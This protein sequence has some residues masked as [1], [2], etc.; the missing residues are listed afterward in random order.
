M[1]KM[2]RFLSSEPIVKLEKAFSN[3]FRNLVATAQTCYSG[4]GIVSED[5]ITEDYRKLA[6]SIYKAGH[7]TTLQHAH[8]QFSISNVYRQFVWSF[9]HSHPFY[10]SEQV[11]QRY[12]AVKPGNFL[13]PPLKGRALALYEKTIAFQME[14]YS[15]LSKELL[16]IARNEYLKLFRVYEAR[17]SKRKKNRRESPQLD[18]PFFKSADDLNR[19]VI[20][21][22]QEAARYVIPVAAFTCL[23]HTISAVTLLRYYRLCKM[24]DTPSEQQIVVGKMVQEVLRAEPL[25]KV[26]IEEPLEPDAIPEYQFFQSEKHD[27]TSKLTKRF[28]QEFDSSLDG[29]ISRLID[30]KHLNEAVLAQSVREVLGI[31]SSTLKDKKNFSDRKAIRLVLDPSI[32]KLYGE[33]LNLSTISKLTRTLSHV[34]YTFRK[35]I[36]HTADSQDQRHRTTPASRPCLHRHITDEPDYITPAIIS[37][38]SRIEKRYSETMDRI[39]DSIT[40]LRKLGVSN[41]FAMYLLPNAV[42]VR[43]TESGDLLN[44]RHKYAMR[45]CYNAQEEIWRASLDEVEQ[46]SRVNPAIGKYLLPPCTSRDMADVRPVC[47]EGERF[48]GVKV[49]RLRLKDYRR[50]I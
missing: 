19:T 2:T 15:R 4:K 23:Y 36:S 42:A 12:V 48:C 26:I 3:P 38:D 45:L 30:Y 35:R 8:F 10:N 32:N 33:T 13:V 24:Y 6:K 31:P 41:E 39:W 25:Y 22:A 21:K 5:N 46:I 47:P 11:S 49:W 40:R 9:L 37:Q 1:N 7:H 34:S 43:F 28:L 17:G 16:P 50:I 29:R 18:L 20:K 14:E 27:R 44:L